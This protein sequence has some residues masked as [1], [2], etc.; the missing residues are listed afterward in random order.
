MNHRVIV[1]I[2]AI[3]LLANLGM[4]IFLIEEQLYSPD[5]RPGIFGSTNGTISGEQR[6]QLI[7]NTLSVSNNNFNMSNQSP[8]FASLQGPAVLT[9]VSYSRRGQ[10]LYQETN[11]TGTMTNISVEIVPG[12]GRVL[13]QTTPLMGIVFQDAAN[14]AV[15]VTRDQTKI[16]LSRFDIIYSIKSNDLI[17]AIDGPSA[18]ALMTIITEAAITGQP[19][20]ENRTLTGTINPDGSIG[21]IGG[22]VEK[23]KAAKEAGK[24]LLLLPQGNANLVLL[25]ENVRNVGGFRL[26]EQVPETTPAKEYIEST[27]GI[28]VEYVNTIND[29][30]HYL[31]QND[32]N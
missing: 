3:S 4:G 8:R 11:E 29:V 2:L 6:N 7:G 17:P 25:N 5:L 28:H 15:A 10:F 27:V 23:A 1:A 12:E 16:D 18:G 20:W 21:P 9:T 32:L 19:L 31:L 22:I 14:T 24:D 30:E 13:V 26:V